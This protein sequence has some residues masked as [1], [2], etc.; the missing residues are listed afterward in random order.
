M[1]HEAQGTEHVTWNVCVCVCVCVCVPS[2]T[3]LASFDISPARGTA[4]QILASNIFVISH[5]FSHLRVP[6]VQSVLLSAFVTRSKRLARAKR[7]KIQRL[8]ASSVSREL[9]H[10]GSLLGGLPG[11]RENHEHAGARSFPYLACAHRAAERQTWGGIANLAAIEVKS[12][13]PRRRRVIAATFLEADRA[14]RSEENPTNF[15][16][17]SFPFLSFFR[18]I[19]QSDFGIRDDTLGTLKI[20][21]ET[22]ISTW[23]QVIHVCWML[24]SFRKHQYKCM[25]CNCKNFKGNEAEWKIKKIF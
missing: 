18:K 10:T 1:E 14:T 19:S 17:P 8:V 16:S 7:P 5:T 6:V 4:R 22:F 13:F 23:L 12:D 15:H 2:L 25:W 24:D 21:T 3:N 11:E 20:Q 9:E